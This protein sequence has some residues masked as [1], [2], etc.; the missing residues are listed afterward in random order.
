LTK[1]AKYARSF[2]SDK[3]RC[4][5]YSPKTIIPGGG[6]VGDRSFCPE[7]NFSIG[8]GE[9]CREISRNKKN[10]KERN[11]QNECVNLIWDLG[12]LLKQDGHTL[13]GKSNILEG[14]IVCIQSLQSALR[15]IQE[16]ENNNLQKKLPTGSLID[17]E[18]AP[19]VSFPQ[20]FYQSSIPLAVVSSQGQI[21]TLNWQFESATGLSNNEIPAFII[22][23]TQ[24]HLQDL[25]QGGTNFCEEN[26][27]ECLLSTPVYSTGCVSNG[28]RE[29]T[30]WSIVH[31]HKPFWPNPLCSL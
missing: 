16:N 6:C 23:Q 5:G 7:M 27:C 12:E 3:D 19:D 30:V 17:S 24:E 13:C 15:S 22:L 9:H 10:L 29:Q 2:T 26:N 28:P 31:H 4:Q 14:A 20:I 18:K 25:L 8:S 1:D 21:L 11:R